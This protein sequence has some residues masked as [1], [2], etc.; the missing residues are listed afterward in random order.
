MGPRLSSRGGAPYASVRR[1]VGKLRRAEPDEPCAVIET[2]PGEETQVDYGTGP[3]VRDRLVAAY[4]DRLLL[5]ATGNGR[6]ARRLTDVTSLERGPEVLLTPRVLL[7]AAA[8]PLRPRV[9][10]AP[11][12]AEEREAAGL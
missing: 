5:T 9:E 7:A 1:F 2:K 12:T 10:E 6:V 11:L 8:G 4:V 3:T